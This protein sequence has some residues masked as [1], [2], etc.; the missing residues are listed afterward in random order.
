MVTA[1]PDF[2][3]VWAGLPGPSRVLDAA[4]R[5]AERGRLGPRSTI[6]VALSAA[7]RAEVGR[8]L[9]ASW[10]AGIAPV[11]T[12][13]LRAGLLEHGVTLE[14]LLVALGGPL[15]DL[16]G[17]RR[18]AR[19]AEAR[20]RAAALA[21]LRMLLAA[22]ATT[23][24]AGEDGIDEE[25]SRWVLRRAPAGE[26]ARSVAAVVGAL[27]SE[28]FLLLAVLAARLFGDAHA[29]DRSRPL[30]RAV[31]R[32]LAVRSALAEAAGGGDLDVTDP[33]G[34]PEGWRAAWA[35][36]GVACD[37]VSSLVLVLN[38]PLVG[39]APAVG[40]CAAAPGEP[41]WLTLRSLEGR[42][43]LAGST[44]VHVCE[45]PS[46]VEAA[47]AELGAAA[48]P[49]VCTFGR[50]SAAAWVLLRGMGPGARLRVR[51]DGDATGW[52]IVAALRAEFPDAEAWRMPPG[53]SAFEEELVD[54][55]LADLAAARGRPEA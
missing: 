21:Q 44:V 47:A 48:G 8:L 35:C 46:I 5:R 54:S 45:N 17:E 42:F 20:D 12:T 34:S 22:P 53:T 29:L 36:G 30:G 7:E 15:R 55:L 50:P 19:A 6:D 52:S 31:A 28:G 41:V 13:E 14:D 1:V 39:E 11:R 18:A 43:G 32:F 2:L 3:R 33:V 49:L 37:A 38:L 25:L 10:L 23:D 16:D 40:L 9:P 51:A 27:P 4:R 24:R 26:R